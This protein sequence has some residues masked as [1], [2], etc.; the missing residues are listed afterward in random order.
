M[1]RNRLGKPIY[2]NAMDLELIVQTEYSQSN[3]KI[4]HPDF[5]FEVQ[6]QPQNNIQIQIQT[7]HKTG[8]GFRASQIRFS[9]LK[10][11]P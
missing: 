8:I 2:G 7:Q 9:K 4:K 11:V 3:W 10:P 6:V 1:P 5:K